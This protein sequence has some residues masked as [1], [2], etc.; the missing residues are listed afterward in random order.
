MPISYSDTKSPN[1]IRFPNPRRRP[2][3]IKH[4][5]IYMAQEQSR[6]VEQQTP[7]T[8]IISN[9]LQRTLAAENELKQAERERKSAASE[10]KTLLDT[11]RKIIWNMWKSVTAKCSD[12]PYQATGW[13]FHYK[14]N[15]GNVILPKSLEERL[16]TL[17]TYINQEQSQPEQQRFPI[18]DLM[19]VIDMHTALEG[20]A[21]TRAASLR[22]R[23]SQVE[24][25]NELALEL[26]NY[27][28]AAGIYL[29]A[30][31]FKF[32]L[33]KDLQNWGYDIA[34]KS[35]T[36]ARETAAG[37]TA[38]DTTGSNNSEP[39]ALDSTLLNGTAEVGLE[40]VDGDS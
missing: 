8:P 19:D 20:Q 35:S 1:T 5:Q 22:K 26:C 15:T 9:L 21:D 10:L 32:K 24:K 40:V 37:E 36:S 7:F 30:M 12:K 6:P 23:E 16:E 28:Q 3:I 4:G 13:G 14:A 29:L 11:G 31:E 27:L 18:P 34:A 25:C 17:N 2:E 39:A 38:P 33:S